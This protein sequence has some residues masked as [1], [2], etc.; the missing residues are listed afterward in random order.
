MEILPV[1]SMGR[2]NT[3]T[4]PLSPTN[5]AQR[6]FA[7]SDN[8]YTNHVLGL[9][10][11][12]VCVAN[13][14]PLSKFG[15]ELVS[16]PVTP[17]PN[18]LSKSRNVRDNTS[19]GIL[20]SVANTTN[21]SNKDRGGCTP[22]RLNKFVRR[23]HNMLVREK[24]SGIVE[25]RRGL[26]VLFSTDAFSKRILP[27]YFNTRNFKTFRRQL[28]YYGFVHVRSFCATGNTTTALWINQH[29]AED[30][31]NDDMSAVLKLRRVE[32]DEIAKTVEGRRL[33]KE[34]A[35]HTVEGEIG[36]NSKM[37]QLD[38]VRS[39]AVRRKGLPG[40][41]GHR[42]N[43]EHITNDTPINIHQVTDSENSI[44]GNSG[45]T[46]CSSN[47]DAFPVKSS[48]RFSSLPKRNEAENTDAAASVLLMLSRS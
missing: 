22:L 24:N 15:S 2:D 34:L 16:M 23:L 12:K 26:L 32:P 27:K 11:Q 38:Q 39:M 44:N 41:R 19:D 31:A 42:S 21:K 30:E 14:S 17:D 47:D 43:Q 36:L 1:Q 10:K 20:S 35:I 4:I 25:W 33:R 29:L 5:S 40:R 3:I 8:S 13:T 45:A 46:T 28:N 6:L 18:F 48:T 9:T 7:T 37:M